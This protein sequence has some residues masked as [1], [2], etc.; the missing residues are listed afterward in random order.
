MI[1]AM[2]SLSML[3]SNYE[4]MKKECLDIKPLTAL[5]LKDKKVL[6]MLAKCPLWKWENENCRIVTM[7][8]VDYWINFNFYWVG[9]Y[10]IFLFVLVLCSCCVMITHKSESRL[11]YTTTDLNNKAFEEM[12][13]GPGKGAMPLQKN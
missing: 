12:E 11:D 8:H 6:D 2:I 4:G 13:M 1:P 7:N 3:V 5:Q 9:I 10:G